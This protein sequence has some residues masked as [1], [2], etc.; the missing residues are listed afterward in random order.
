MLALWGLA[1]AVVTVFLAFE[2]LPLPKGVAPLKAMALSQGTPEGEVSL[3]DNWRSHPERPVTTGIYSARFDHPGGGAKWAVYIPS[4]SGQIEVALNGVEL[5]SGGFISGE[6][7]ADQGAPFYAPI[8]PSALEPHDNSLEITLHPGGLLTGFLSQVYIG[9]SALIRTSFDWYY[10]RAV[11]LPLLVVFWQILLA[12]LLFLLWYSRRSERAALYCT[13]LLLLSSVHGIPVFLPSSLALTETVAK[14]G[15]VTNLWLSVVSLLFIY[16][17]TDRRLPVRAGILL[18]LP[19]LATLAF[20]LLPREIFRYIDLIAVVPFSLVMTAWVFFMLVRSAVWERRWDS[21]ILLL[22]V[23]GAVVLA[24]HDTLIIANLLPDS[25]FLHFRIVYILILP[26]LS[27][28]FLQRLIDSMNRVD[29]LANTLED[30]IEQKELQLRETFEQRQVLEGRQALNEE[31]QRIMRDVHDGLGGQLMSIIAMATSNEAK[32][33]AIES[34]ARAALEDLRTMINSLGAEDDITGILGT[35]RERAEQQLALQGIELDWNMI[36]IPPI[37]GLTPSAALNV[38]RIMQ[39]AV[40]NA[41]KHSGADKVTIRFSLL[42]RI[43]EMLNIEIED[44]GC[45][46]DQASATGHGLKNMVARAQAIRGDIEIES[47][48][49]GTLVSLSIPTK[50]ETHARARSI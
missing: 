37:E 20:A 12:A 46:L 10:F 33:D 36:E 50:Y 17:F 32:P 42:P 4:Y 22:S 24:L 7:G 3:P 31:R 6:L 1:V 23:I 48:G 44:N 19:A 15:Y 38:M 28:I 16:A 8:S 21:T 5:T 39:E 9:P 43:Q 11:L 30:R 29:S 26:A 2:L 18:L 41:A 47:T 34:S 40:T 49:A 45:G 27:V 14:L 13:A 25:N 35:F